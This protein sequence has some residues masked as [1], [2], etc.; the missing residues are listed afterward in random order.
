VKSS[1]N[2]GAKILSRHKARK[3]PVEEATGLRV[4]LLRIHRQLRSHSA[5]G[6]TLSQGSA[7]ARIEQLGPLRLGVL[8]EAEGTTAA[9]M[10]KVVDSLEERRLI[11]RVADPL[12]GRASLIQLGAQGGALLSDVRQRS[13]EV[14]RSAMDEMTVSERETISRAIPAL[15]H[16]SEILSRVER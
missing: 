14:L 9:T 8:A 6:V 3:D 12:D 2:N 15:E 10:C 16:L 1:S 7:L 5:V 13:T 11:E 4:A